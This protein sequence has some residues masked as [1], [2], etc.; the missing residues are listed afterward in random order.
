M[1]RTFGRLGDG[2]EVIEKQDV[3]EYLRQVGFGRGLFGGQQLEMGVQQIMG[4]FDDALKALPQGDISFLGLPRQPEP[5][6]IAAMTEKVRG[7]CI[8]VR[9]AGHESVLA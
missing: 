2:R 5:E 7:S 1:S 4:S 8:F 3:E 6:L 9:D